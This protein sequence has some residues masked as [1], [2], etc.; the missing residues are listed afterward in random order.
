MGKGRIDPEYVAY[1]IDCPGNYIITS[2]ADK[3][4]F[5]PRATRWAAAVRYLRDGLG[6]WHGY[7]HYLCR[8][9]KRVVPI[10]PLNV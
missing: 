2:L 5:G 1:V 9:G 3:T 4:K 8:S 7:T 10:R 6:R